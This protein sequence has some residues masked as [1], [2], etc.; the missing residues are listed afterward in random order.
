MP[1][2]PQ[3]LSQFLFHWLAIFLLEDFDAAG[4]VL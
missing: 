1:F 2:S 4:D 3:F